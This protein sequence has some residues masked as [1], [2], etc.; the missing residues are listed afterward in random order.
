M[1]C[2]SQNPEFPSTSSE[3]RSCAYTFSRIC[4]GNTRNYTGRE[5]GSQQDFPCLADLC[6]IRL[7][8]D[9]LVTTNPTVN[10]GVCSTAGDTVVVRSPSGHTTGISYPPDNICGTLT[11][12]H[13]MSFYTTTVWISS[14]TII[15]IFQCT[16]TLEP[17]EMLEPSLLPPALQLLGVVSGS[18]WPILNVL[19]IWSRNICIKRINFMSNLC[20]GLFFYKRAPDGCLQYFTGTSGT[21]SSYNHQGGVQLADQNYNLCLRQ[22]EGKR[23]CNNTT[24]LTCI[25][26]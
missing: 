1:S 8:F 18:K 20:F 15:F 12:Q 5:T 4:A 19:I 10:T 6:Q 21:I 2:L 25:K 16:L 14:L 3:T 17:L 26:K 13:S 7:D 9:N 11:G 23:K 24:I 22:E